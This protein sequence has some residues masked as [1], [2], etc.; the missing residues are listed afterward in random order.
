MYIQEGPYGHNRVLH[1]VECI[2]GV[3]ER[4]LS[5]SFQLLLLLLDIYSPRARCGPVWQW[6]IALWM[7][8]GAARSHPEAVCS[9]S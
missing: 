8:A 7:L 1:F 4:L 3:H 5:L 2:V 6:L 9:C